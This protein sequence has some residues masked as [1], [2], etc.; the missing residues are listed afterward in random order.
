M[1]NSL[2]DLFH[3]KEERKPRRDIAPAPPTR[4]LP[5]SPTPTS[6][7]ERSDSDRPTAEEMA[8]C[9]ILNNVPTPPTRP[10]GVART[11]SDCLPRGR[12][13]LMNSKGLSRRCIWGAGGAADQG[14]DQQPTS[15]FGRLSATNSNSRSPPQQRGVARTKSLET[16]PVSRRGLVGSMGRR[17]MWNTSVKAMGRMRRAI[18]KEESEDSDSDSSES[19]SDSDDDTEETEKAASPWNSFRWTSK[20]SLNSAKELDGDSDDSDSDDSDRHVTKKDN[21]KALNPDELRKLLGG[22]TPSA[23]TNEELG[24]MLGGFNPGHS[25]TTTTAA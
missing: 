5:E 8:V 10:R 19:E 22:F 18:Q 1:P 14:S 3:G 13:N 7:E 12:P 17:E 9:R 20:H 24:A 11:K 2:R 21:D 6:D 23:T 25:A 15:R 16:G 4:R